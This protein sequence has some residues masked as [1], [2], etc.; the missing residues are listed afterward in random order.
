MVGMEANIDYPEYDI[1]EIT[2]KKILKMLNN[3]KKDLEK[4]AKTFENGKIIKDGIKM[5]IIGS[6]NAGKSS[7]LNAI[8]R[9]DRAI[10]TA[11]EGT[12]RDTIEE[13]IQISGIPFKI[14][15]TAG[16]RKSDNQIEK[17]GIEKTRKIAKESDLIIAMFDISKQV[18]SEDKEILEIIKDKKAIIVLNKLDLNKEILAEC[19]EI[20]DAGKPVIKISALNK[21]GIDEIYKEITKMF[22]LNEINVDNEVIITN[23]RHRELINEAILNTKQAIET[24]KAEMPIDIISINI[25]EILENLAK[26]TGESVSEDILKEIFSKFCLGK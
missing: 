2:N 6:P 13:S 15:D 12:T 23:I 7:L 9:E 25:K 16:I 21:K 8:L 26:I 19:N 14:I 11:I 1:E 10:V 3:I 22:N 17:I 18:S 5:A 24:L 4:L 20:M